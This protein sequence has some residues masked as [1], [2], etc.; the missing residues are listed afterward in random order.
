MPYAKQVYGILLC[1]ARALVNAA[2]AWVDDLEEKAEPKP[3]SKKKI[4]M[5]KGSH[6]I[7]PKLYEGNFAYTFQHTDNRVVFAI[8]YE[9]E[10]TLIGTTD[11][12]YDAD[13]NTVAITKSEEAYLCQVA[14]SY[15]EKPIQ[16]DQIKWS[17]S[18]I[19]P[20]VDDGEASASKTTR[21]YVLELDTQEGA[22]M[23]SVYGG[24]I[25]TFRCLAEDVMKKL[26][27]HLAYTA[28]APLPGGEMG[29]VGL[30]H[31]HKEINSKYPWLTKGILRRLVKAY[32]TRTKAVIRD[33]KSM[34]DLGRNFGAGLYEAELLYLKNE[35]WAN[36]AQDALWRRSK[37]GLHMT[38]AEQIAVDEW[39]NQ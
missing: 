22:P 4:R 6:I 10:Y 31:F 15:F 25:T 17:Y 26:Q 36:T 18:G 24:K 1:K 35:E 8:P 9:G 28:K 14:S 29:Y 27:P 3:R 20:L 5:V 32:G 38:E 19:R 2:G 12:P 16:Q 23:L 34:K 11:V 13:P 39:F 33:A 7:V 37:L 30:D 21:D